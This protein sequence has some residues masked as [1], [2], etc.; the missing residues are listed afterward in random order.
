MKNGTAVLY[1][2]ALV[3]AL[4]SI[5]IAAEPA[6]VRFGV[7]A[8]SMRLFQSAGIHIAQR[9]GMFEKQGL[10][11]DVVP[12]PGVEHMTNALDKDTVDISM[13]ATPY[14]VKAVLNGSDATAII[15][16]PANT[17]YNIVGRPEV[18]SMEQLRGKTVALSLPE[19]MISITTR[20][21]LAKHGLQEKDYAGKELIGTP[22]RSKCLESAECAAA[23]LSQ[24]EDLSFLRK[25]YRVLGNSHEVTPTMQFTVFAARKP[26]AAKNKDVVVR[27]TKAIEEAYAFTANPANREEVVK[28]VVE[29]TGASAED[30]RE[31]Y[32]LY[33]EPNKGVMPKRGEINVEGVAKV[34]ELL[35]TASLLQKPLPAPERF[36][37]LEYLRAA[38]IQ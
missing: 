24:P 9:K 13:V 17:I 31:I 19:D 18:T 29:A 16:G 15:G 34:I 37:D 12:L 2:T 30:S 5:A 8:A 4:P 38:G 10:K 3:L 11:V 22:L 26:W 27:F 23:P 20:M 14:L 6:T 35:G 25:G 32:K 36:I 21:I 28:I 1:A 33:Y 7:I